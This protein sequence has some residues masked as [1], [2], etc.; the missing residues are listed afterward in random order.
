MYLMA[1]LLFVALLA[2]A[3]MRPVHP[4]YHLDARPPIS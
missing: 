4:R 3:F 2:N 1:S